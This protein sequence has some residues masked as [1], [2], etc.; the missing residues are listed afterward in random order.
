M[1]AENTIKTCIEKANKAGLKVKPDEIKF[2]MYVRNQDKL[3]SKGIYGICWYS[4]VYYCENDYN[5]PKFP[6]VIAQEFHHDISYFDWDQGNVTVGDYIVI[7]GLVDSFVK[8][9]YGTDQLDLGDYYG[10]GRL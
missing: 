8:E 10:Q 4:W 3:T 7:E 6:A 1:V 5:L 9:L 2:G